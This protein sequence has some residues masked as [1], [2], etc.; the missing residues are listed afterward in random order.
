LQLAAKSARRA[1]ESPFGALSGLTLTKMLHILRQPK[2]NFVIAKFGLNPLA[3]LS[4]IFCKKARRA[5]ILV[6]EN[7]M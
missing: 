4:Q 6:V 3:E 5:K 2:A 7:G 1:D